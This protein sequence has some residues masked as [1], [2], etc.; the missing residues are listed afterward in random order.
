V[1]EARVFYTGDVVDSETRA[2]SL[3]A[4]AENADRTLKPGMFV[5]V[6]LP[7]SAQASVLQ[8]PLTA[9][10]EHEGRPFVFVHL[11]DDRF[12]RRDVTLGRRTATSVEVREG[13]IAGDAIV[14]RGG[15]ALKSRLLAAL[16]A[17]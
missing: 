15:F 3:R 16:L 10:Q 1:F 5:T 7:V 8:V 6:E 4:I 11:G 12:E 13:V 2:M 9:I 17:E 14:V